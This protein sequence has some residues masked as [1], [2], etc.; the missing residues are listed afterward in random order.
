[1]SGLIMFFHSNILYKI[2]NVLRLDTISL[3]S[4]F[5]PNWSWGDYHYP[6]SPKGGKHGV[7]P[8]PSWQSGP[9]PLIVQP[10]LKGK[11]GVII[12]D[13]YRSE[14]RRV[15]KECRDRR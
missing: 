9:L 10:I 15:G 11:L 12:Q 3:L 4:C 13:S 5:V 1:M 2:I 7:E 8:S 6:S 14:E